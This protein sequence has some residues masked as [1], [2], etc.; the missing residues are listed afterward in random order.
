MVFICEGCDNN[1]DPIWCKHTWWF[2]VS[3]HWGTKYSLKN[4]FYKAVHV[5]CVVSVRFFLL[6]AGRWHV[7]VVSDSKMAM[8][9]MLLSFSYRASIFFHGVLGYKLGGMVNEWMNRLGY[10]RCYRRFHTR[11]KNS[12]KEGCGGWYRIFDNITRNEKIGLWWMVSKIWWW[13]TT[14]KN[15]WNYCKTFT[16]GLGR[17]NIRLCACRCKRIES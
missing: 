15:S 3:I 9:E 6:T 7:R 5:T 14:M 1:V 10:G 2:I 8:W 4:T 16:E 13:N 17:G 11:I 12:W